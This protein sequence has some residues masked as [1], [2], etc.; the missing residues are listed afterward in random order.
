MSGLI[1]I[2]KGN[3]LDSV[4]HG[5]TLL[6]SYGEGGVFYKMLVIL[7]L[8]SVSA[9][10]IAKLSLG[11]K[12][13]YRSSTIATSLTRRKGGPKQLALTVRAFA[14]AFTHTPN[15]RRGC[16]KTAPQRPS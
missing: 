11:S 10:P 5:T 14:R 12:V 9:S 7:I 8:C 15:R 2:E 4:T 16:P 3:R 13:G 6:A 1:L